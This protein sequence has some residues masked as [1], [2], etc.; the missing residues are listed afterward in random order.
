[1]SV[2]TWQECLDAGMTAIEA[3][4]ARDRDRANA[5]RWAQ[6]RGL[7]W[8]DGVFRVPVTVRGEVFPSIAQAAKAMGLAPNTLSQ[9]LANHGHLDRA[10]SGTARDSNGSGGRRKPVT[11]AGRHFASQKAAAKALGTTDAYLRRLIRNGRDDL[12]LARLMKAD[13]RRTAQAMKAAQMVDGP[14]LDAY[15][16][17][18]QKGGL[19]NRRAAA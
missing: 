8:P 7:Q 18:G 4:N 5:Y 3:S 13:A 14:S 9:H 6:R 2:P 15:R 16:A 12:I 11:L 10:G 19:L 1:M 17:G